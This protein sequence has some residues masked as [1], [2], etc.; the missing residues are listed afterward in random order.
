MG[1]SPL[2]QPGD[3]A[4]R[5]RLSPKALRLYAEQGL[6]V[7]AHVD[8]RT[9]YRY[10]AVSQID[11]A[12]LIGLLRR[13]GMPLARVR[14]VLDLDGPA[15]VAAIG[16]WWATVEH[17]LEVRRE[18]VHYLD[19]YLTGRQELMYDVQL[20]DVPEQKLLTAE[21]RLTVDALDDFID[22]ATAAITR[23][24]DESGLT[25]CGQLRV[26]FH[27]MVTEDSDGPVEVAVPFAGSV[28]PVGELRVRLQPAGSEAFTR[29]TRVQSEFPGILD[30]YRAVGHWIDQKPMRRAGSPAE[31]YLVGPHCA[32]ADPDAPYFDVAWPAQPT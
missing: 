9:G 28:E 32:D 11:R 10:Y 21:R 6:L 18:L 23:H 13:A 16:R 25:P 22:T 29:L 1:D 7:P 5:V 27:G 3:F 30:A 2:I 14:I 12:Y 24:L 17:D 8:E 31:V 15:L 4:T 19:R 20:R 26:I